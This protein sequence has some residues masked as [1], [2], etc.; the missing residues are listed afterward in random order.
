MNYS[1][2]L[3]D[4]YGVDL[5]TSDLKLEVDGGVVVPH[6][7]SPWPDGEKEPLWFCPYWRGVAGDTGAEAGP[8]SSAAR[9]TAFVVN[10]ERSRQTITLTD[11][12]TLLC[13]YEWVQFNDMRCHRNFSFDK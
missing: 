8:S 11:A 3:L 1:K 4:E 13:I 12:L 10:E 5:V 9:W 2:H 6:E 7:G